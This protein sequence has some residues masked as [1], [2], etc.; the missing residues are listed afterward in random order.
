MTLENVVQKNR[1]QELLWGKIKYFAS[2]HDVK[3]QQVKTIIDANGVT[4]ILKIVQ[5]KYARVP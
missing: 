5:S 2:Y 1:S 4:E 3:H